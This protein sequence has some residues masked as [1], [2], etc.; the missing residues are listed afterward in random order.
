MSFWV[1]QW[2]WMLLGLVALAPLGWLLRRAREKRRLVRE[3]LGH[4]ETESIQWR[5]WTWL[6]VLALLAIA[7]ARPGYDPVR[8]SI[9]KS[10]RDV[11][12][13]LDISRSMLA[14]DAYP[15]RL[16]AAKQGIRDCLDGFRGEQVGLV[17]YAGSASISCPLTADYE[18]LRY[19]VSQVEPRSVEFGGTMLLSAIEKVVDQVLDSERRGFQDLIILTDGEDHG[20]DMKR[21]AD[22]VKE[23][24]VD[25][26]IVGL[27]D[28][29]SGSRIPI[30]NEDGNTISLK[31]AGSVVYTKLQDRTLGE[32]ARLCPDS[33]YQ[34]AGTLP[35]HLGD[36]YRTFSEGKASTA[37]GA[38]A[39]YIVYREAAFFLMPLAF[40]LA[41]AGRFRLGGG[42]E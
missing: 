25:L 35:F 32:L 8:H 23:S 29:V 10:G 12:F 28:S 3:S 18:F 11:V 30:L 20:P 15:S 22:A 5:D 6:G 38:D 19:M 7:L 39:G 21:V 41:L 4:P 24:G 17:I 2:P 37:M 31:H 36:F 26:L 33:Q 16:E 40:V 34:K 14:Q 9:S 42:K 1:F 27:G 13:V